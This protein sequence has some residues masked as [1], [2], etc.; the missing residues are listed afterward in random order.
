[1]AKKAAKKTAAKL[2]KELDA[3]FSRYIRLSHSDRDGFVNCFTCNRR[4]FWK[5]IQNGHF[6]SR[7]YLAVRYSEDNCRPQCVGCNIYGN[8]KPVEYARNL[9][10]HQKGVT[11]RLYREAQ[12]V[13]KNYPYEE[14]IAYYTKKLEKYKHLLKR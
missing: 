6:I 5:D 8:G 9:E 11:M 4:Y 7:T 2:K 13:V 10:L 12:A 14:K 1:M 3:V